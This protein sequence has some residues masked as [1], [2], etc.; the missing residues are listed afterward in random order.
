MK[1]TEKISL[2][3]KRIL[4]TRSKEGWEEWLPH[5][6]REGA[7]AIH[8][9]T[10]EI[11]PPDDWSSVDLALSK[12]SSYD[13]LVF[14]SQSAVRFFFDRYKTIH[15]KIQPFSAKL[16]AIGSRTAES[17][18]EYVGR[19][20]FVPQNPKAAEELG[21][22]LAQEVTLKG[23]KI[24]IP[25]A[26]EAREWLPDFLREQGA[27]VEALT[28]YQTLPSGKG[29]EALGR[30]R[31]KGVDWLVFASPSSVDSFL[32]LDESTKMKEWIRGKKM[33]VAAIGRVTAKHLADENIKVTAVASEPT[34]ESLI[35]KMKDASGD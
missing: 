23:S 33:R 15:E 25:R 26:E 35:T 10:I 20:D 14:T 9:P 19:I 34:V 31:D 27:H 30:A 7:I 29:R 11:H 6:K 18:K 17:I 2:S 12:L 32:R 21:E 1:V 4:I 3:G 22:L 24:L 16:A 5:F 13:V 28:V 8:V